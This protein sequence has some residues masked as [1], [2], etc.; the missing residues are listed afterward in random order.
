MG[1][2]C[3]EN[4]IIVVVVVVVVVVSLYFFS[5]ELLLSPFLFCTFVP[6]TAANLPIKHSESNSIIYKEKDTKQDN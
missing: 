3:L 6:K 2:S 4:I 5:T 1:A